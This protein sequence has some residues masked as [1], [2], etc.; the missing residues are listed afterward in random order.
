MGC[1]T[2]GL[3]TPIK[4]TCLVSHIQTCLVSH[5]LH[6]IRSRIIGPK[7]YLRLGHMSLDTTLFLI[8]GPIEPPLLQWSAEIIM[9]SRCILN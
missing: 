6:T 8:I 1:I 3:F 7:E 5:M 9:L 2:H 4:Q